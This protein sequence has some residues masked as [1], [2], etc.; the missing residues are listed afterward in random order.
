MLSCLSLK[1]MEIFHQLE[2]IIMALVL[3]SLLQGDVIICVLF[4]LFLLQEE[5]KEVEV[6]RVSLEKSKSLQTKDIEKLLFLVKMLIVIYGMVEDRKKISL[7]QVKKKRK[8]Q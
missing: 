5:E 2:F 8:I 3:L 1:L 6:L 7:R 4:V